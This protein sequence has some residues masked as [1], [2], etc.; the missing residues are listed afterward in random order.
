ME[1][2]N[3][4]INTSQYHVFYKNK[5]IEQLASLT[6]P[7]LKIAI[8]DNIKPPKSDKIFFIIRLK[9]NLNSDDKMITITCSKVIITNNL[10]ML[11]D[12]AGDAVTVVYSKNEYKRLHFKRSHIVK[13]INALETESINLEESFINISDILNI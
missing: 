7:K 1:Q 5:E 12:S 2:I 9:V 8:K 11:V 10:D 6:I 13:I 4:I 3:D